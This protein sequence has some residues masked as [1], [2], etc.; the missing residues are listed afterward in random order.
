LFRIS[1]AITQALE[2]ALKGCNN[3]LTVAGAGL[4]GGGEPIIHC[5]SLASISTA[6]AATTW[7]IT[8]TSKMAMIED[9]ILLS[10]VL[11]E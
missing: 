2:A 10:W 7:P 3:E 6:G 11:V 5:G 9:F 8:A 1:L 4:D